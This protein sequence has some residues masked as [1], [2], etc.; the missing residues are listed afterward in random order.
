MAQPKLEDI[1]PSKLFEN[2]IPIHS[3]WV[4][5]GEFI[6]KAAPITLIAFLAFIMATLASEWHWSEF[7]VWLFGLLGL[8]FFLLDIYALF[9]FEDER[10]DKVWRRNVYNQQLTIIQVAIT[11][12]TII[13]KANNVYTGTP[14]SQPQLNTGDQQIG[15]P[16]ARTGML[17]P[18]IDTEL[19]TVYVVA[20]LIAERA[21]SAWRENGNKR[22]KTKPIAFDAITKLIEV[23]HPRWKEACKLLEDAKVMQNATTATWQPLVTDK[24]LAVSLVDSLLQA[25]GYY[26]HLNNSNQREWRRALPQAQLNKGEKQ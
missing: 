15:I 13:Q 2:P 20:L 6:K 19:N 22:P 12:L 4:S 25:R 21:I 8:T 23:G 11:N 14:Q 26:A 9:V 16:E 24:A 10:A 17:Y 5:F 7:V 1:I 18:E 3:H